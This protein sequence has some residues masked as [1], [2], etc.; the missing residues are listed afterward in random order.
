MCIRDRFRLAPAAVLVLMVAGGIVAAKVRSLMA[1]VVSMG[2]IGF[3]S[4]LIF[5][6]NGAPD[7]ALTQFSVEVLVVLILTALLL[8]MPARTA[9]SRT[10]AER[11]LDAVLSI[12]FAGLVFTGLVAMTGAPLDTTLSEFYGRTSYVEAYG[13]NV[14]NVILVDFRALDTMGEIAVIGF[15]AIGVWLSLIHI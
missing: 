10:I 8:R 1:S 2:M 7:L 3:G 14:V 5:L 6:M 11:R 4:A 12:A 13:R 15:A 9:A